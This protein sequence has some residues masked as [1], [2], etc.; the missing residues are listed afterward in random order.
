MYK[1][2]FH[3]E[4][5]SDLDKLSNKT[6]SKVRHYFNK[7]KDNPYKY[8]QELEN[9]DGLNLQGYCKTYLANATCRIVFKIEENKIKIVEVVAVGKREDKQVY[10]DAYNRIK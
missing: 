4:V 10:K 1:L 9:L 6:V 2:I 3:K 8:S 5:F 7:Y